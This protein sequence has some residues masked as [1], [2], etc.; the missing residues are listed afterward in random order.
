MGQRNTEQQRLK[1]KKCGA[2][3]ADRNKDTDIIR[4]RDVSTFFFF[5]KTHTGRDKTLEDYDITRVSG[6]AQ[7][8]IEAS[9]NAFPWRRHPARPMQTPL[10]YIFW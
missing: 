3:E 4:Q 6:P 7:W 8:P 9:I 2:T 10:C 1:Q 5:L